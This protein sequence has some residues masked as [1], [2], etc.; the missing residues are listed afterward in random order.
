MQAEA[1]SNVEK[2]QI[3]QDEAYIVKSGDTLYKIANKFGVDIGELKEINNLSNNMIYP[4]QKLIIPQN[5]KGIYIVKYGDTLYE[6]SAKYNISVEELRIHNKLVSNMIY[7]GDEIYIPSSDI[8]QTI[9]KLSPGIIRL[10]HNGEDVKRVQR[11]LNT[12]GY[13]I[14]ES[15]EYDKTTEWA[16]KDFQSQY[17][18]LMNDGVYGPNTRE[19]LI[20]AILSDHRIVNNF[21]NTLVVVNKE[22]SLP[23]DYEPENLVIPSVRFT[24]EEY[25]EKKLLRHDSASALKEL[26]ISAKKEGVILYAQSGYRSYDRQRQIFG[27]KTMTRGMT[28]A[29]RFSA[30]AGESEHQTGLAMDITSESVGFRLSQNFGETKEGKWLKENSYKF[31]FIIRYPKGKERVTGYQYE[32]WHIRY[33][34]KDI[35]KEIDDKELTLE[36]YMNIK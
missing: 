12:L 35:A 1:S 32:P 19:Y 13:I 27:I 33:V 11:A 15:G 26:F 28:E 22:Y 25:D 5:L 17:Y 34:G 29:N 8:L 7:P 16:I 4:G 31:G 9:H 6:I 30:K 18:K 23:F 24:F 20:K 3:Q 21:S 2:A 14:K 36:E 10:G